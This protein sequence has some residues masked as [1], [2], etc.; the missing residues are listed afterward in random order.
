MS[1]VILDIGA[2]SRAFARCLRLRNWGKRLL[3]FCG[4]P[5]WNPWS[6][7]YVEP[8]RAAEFIAAGAAGAYKIDSKYA[9]FQFADESLD[10]VTVNAPHPLAPAGGIGREADRCLKKDGLIFFASPLYTNSGELPRGRFELVCKN[11]WKNSR[12]LDFSKEALPVGAPTRIPPSFV[13]RNAM[14]AKR[15]QDRN[16]HEPLGTNSYMY[17]QTGVSPKYELWRKI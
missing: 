5:H 9:A 16:P 8:K 13:M 14:W 10:M 17:H 7:G 1:F 6:W 4:E 15:L 12:T 11:A 3:V 2:G